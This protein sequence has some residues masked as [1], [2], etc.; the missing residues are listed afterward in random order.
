M[1]KPVCLALLVLG[2]MLYSAASVPCHAQIVK[3]L[4]QFSQDTPLEMTRLMIDLQLAYFE[5]NSI[6]LMDL[7]I[8]PIIRAENHFAVPVEMTLMLSEDQV[9]AALRGFAESSGGKM[10]A[11]PRA[12]NFSASAESILGQPVL[13]MTVQVSFST[14]KPSGYDN[15]ICEAITALSQ[16][17]TFT[18]QIKK[19]PISKEAKAEA[20]SGNGTWIT[21]LRIDS[22]KHL[23]LTG[24][25]TDT[26]LVNQLCRELEKSG[27]FTE[28]WLNSMTRNVYE[29]QS[30]M[31]FDLSGRIAETTK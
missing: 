11:T 5:R 20:T 21:N 25:A 13:A 9:P 16:A 17:T 14:A 15:S 26:R 1:K 12:V 8:S 2:F 7:R 27:L 24:Y 18:P 22:D 30:V 28:M 10:T 4:K 3:D 29:K 19:K 23:Q 31:R 6:R